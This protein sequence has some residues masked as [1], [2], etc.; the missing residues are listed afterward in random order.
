MRPWLVEFNPAKM[1]LSAI[2]WVRLPNMTVHFYERDFEGGN[3]IGKSRGHDKRRVQEGMFT[4]A[5]ICLKRDA[6]NAI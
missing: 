6:N 4:Y 3:Y 2:P 1:S 5:R